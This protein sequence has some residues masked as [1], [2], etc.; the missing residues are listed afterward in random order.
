MHA[1]LLIAQLSDP[2]IG[3][4]PAFLGGQMDTERALRRAVAHVVAMAPRPD[5]VLLTGDLTERGSAAEYARVADA[6]APLPMPVY[7]VPGNHD[8][9][10]VVRAAGPL[11]AGGAR[12]AGECVLLSL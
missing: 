11:Y 5:L 12:C 6:L 7:A 1:P 2:H 8:D 3:T 4:G 10:R 9:S